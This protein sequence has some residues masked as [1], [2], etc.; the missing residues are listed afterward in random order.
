LEPFCETKHFKKT[1]T[2]KGWKISLTLK[3]NVTEKLIGVSVVSDPVDL[4]SCEKRSKSHFFLPRM[5]QGGE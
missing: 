4:E 1:N 3:E 5:K 2:Q